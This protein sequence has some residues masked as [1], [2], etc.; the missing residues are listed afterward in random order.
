M[1]VNLDS[2]MMCATAFQLQ[3]S[4]AKGSIIIV[5]SI[6]GFQ[7]NIGNP[8]Y[9]ASKAG[10]ISLT[11]TLAK[12]WGRHGIR[13]NGIAPGFVNTK[14]TKVTTGNPDRLAALLSSIPLARLGEPDDMAHAALFL[15][16][17]RASYIAGHTLVV[18]GGVTLS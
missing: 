15:A 7:S 8:A 18:D 2:V 11:R 13:V 4:A 1:A 12:A 16:S 9:S 17:P 10:A 5:S 3:L 6:S 14:L